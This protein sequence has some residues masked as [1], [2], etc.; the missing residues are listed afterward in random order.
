[1]QNKA[2]ITILAIALALVCIYQLSFTGATYKVRKDARE[3]AKGDLVKQNKYTDSIS[4]LPKEM[5]YL[6]YI[7]KRSRKRR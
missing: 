1:M 5:S 4:S 3:Y 7:S 6:G 2:A